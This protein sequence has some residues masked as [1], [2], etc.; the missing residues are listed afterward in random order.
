[1]LLPERTAPSG[2]YRARSHR[3]DT[4]TLSRLAEE[5]AAEIRNHDWSDAPWRADRAGHDRA[6]D[7]RAAATTKQ[8]EPD[9]T[10]TVRVNVMWVTAQVLLHADINLDLHE[11]AIA[12]GVHP[13][14]V[15]RT[16]GSRS[17]GLVNGIRTVGGQVAHPGSWDVG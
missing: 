9:E 14:Y 12:C 1:M 5:F 6:L 11:F 7:R 8:L 17:Q 10:E 15:Y 4:M 2:G 13:R 3:R 16:D